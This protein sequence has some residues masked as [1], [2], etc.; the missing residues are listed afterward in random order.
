MITNFLDYNYK[1]QKKEKEKEILELENIIKLEERRIIEYNKLS[2]LNIDSIKNNPSTISS[3][4]NIDDPINNNITRNGSNKDILQMLNGDFH[5]EFKAKNDDTF[6]LSPN[7]NNGNY[8]WSFNAFNIKNDAG[9]YIGDEYI[10]SIWENNQGLYLGF[11]FKKMNSIQITIIKIILKIQLE[12]RDKFLNTNQLELFIVNEF[13]IIKSIKIICE[14]IKGDDTYTTFVSSRKF[15]L[16]INDNNNLLKEYEFKKTVIS[17]GVSSEINE[18]G[19]TGDIYDQY[20]GIDINNEDEEEKDRINNQRI[21]LSGMDMN[22]ISHIKIQSARTLS[23]IKQKNDNNITMKNVTIPKLESEIEGITTNQTQN[24]TDYLNNSINIYNNN[25]NTIESN[26]EI[27]FN[28]IEH[29][30]RN[31]YIQ[32]TKKIID[33]ITPDQD[34]IDNKNTEEFEYNNSIRNKNFS[35]QGIDIFLK[36]ENQNYLTSNSSEFDNKTHFQISKYKEEKYNWIINWTQDEPVIINDKTKYRSFKL[37]S[38]Y[39]NLYLKVI[40]NKNLQGTKNINEATEFIAIYKSLTKSDQKS[41]SDYKPE[42]VIIALKNSNNVLYSTIDIDNL[43]DV[44]IKN[45]NNSNVGYNVLNND[46]DLYDENARWIISGYSDNIINIYSYDNGHFLHSDINININKNKI[47]G[48]QNGIEKRLTPIHW[49]FETDRS[50]YDNNNLLLSQ[51]SIPI[52]IKSNSKNFQGIN[53]DSNSITTFSS[54]D[55]TEFNLTFKEPQNINNFDDKN[56]L[57]LDVYIRKGL[58]YLSLNDNCDNFT[59]RDDVYTWNIEF[60]KRQQSSFKQL[61]LN[62]ISL[63]R[64]NI[65]DIAKLDLSL[66]YYNKLLNKYNELTTLEH[67]LIDYD[68][69]REIINYDTTVT[70]LNETPIKQGITIPNNY[71]IEF[72]VKI[73]EDNLKDDVCLFRI[74]NDLNNEKDEGMGSRIIACFI[75]KN[76]PPNTYSIDL[77]TGGVE[78]NTYN[79]KYRYNNLKAKQEYT[80]KIKVFNDNYTYHLDGNEVEKI[81]ATHTRGT[82]PQR[83]NCSLKIADKKFKSYQQQNIELKNFKINEIVSKIE[84]S[85]TANK[86]KLQLLNGDFVLQIKENMNKDNFQ[87]AFED[88]TNKNKSKIII[89][90]IIESQTASTTYPEGKNRFIKLNVQIQNNYDDNTYDKINWTSEKLNDHNNPIISSTEIDEIQLIGKEIIINNDDFSFVKRSFKIKINSTIYDITDS[91]G[92]N[93]PGDIYDQNIYEN[94]DKTSKIIYSG[95]LIDTKIRIFEPNMKDKYDAN[96]TLILNTTT[97]N[98]SFKSVTQNKLNNIN[99]SITATNENYNTQLQAL[100]DSN[101]TLYLKDIKR[102]DDYVRNLYV[103]NLSKEITTQEDIVINDDV[104]NRTI[105]LENAKIQKQIKFNGINF[106]IKNNDNKYLLSNTKKETN[107]PLK[108]FWTNESDPKYNWKIKLDVVNTLSIKNLDSNNNFTNKTYFN[109]GIKSNYDNTFLKIISSSDQQISSGYLNSLQ[110]ITWNENNY[111]YIKSNKFDQKEMEVIIL[112]KTNNGYV[113]H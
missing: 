79:Y 70:T 33:N 102:I 59:L 49:R 36:D 46:Y 100:Y 74:Y 93:M 52:K 91:T 113:K 25:L 9:T 77:Y 103:S 35:L 37:K 34:F 26:I 47:W 68:S 80:L 45:T 84:I 58:K 92:I 57:K 63:Y 50:I 10:A 65:L 98:N 81:T 89:K 60:D 20:E 44:T 30:I 27:G 72:T 3:T 7:I 39:N 38:N 86:E 73:N 43:K 17:D 69:R 88:S 12:I 105:I 111:L 106:Q 13:D 23:S 90:Q 62:N 42:N 16:Q 6:D 15:K 94:N 19:I 53:I 29:H 31:I 96:N 8:S 18:F 78:A 64:S 97:E 101:N 107:I 75:E 104:D 71:E 76:T 21:L 41:E 2:E 22:T 56:T 40:N 55:I 87:L 109:A 11:I 99:S 14:T 4:I 54:D 1:I 67:S 66:N 61:E 51:N 24:M 110:N 85:D 5:F 95:P 48:S 83:S 108:L 82:L 112:V 32:N 28:N